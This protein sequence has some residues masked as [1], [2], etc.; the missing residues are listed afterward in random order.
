MRVLVAPD[1]LKGCLTN[2][3]VAQ[4]VA[5]GLHDVWPNAE[6]VHRP[7]SDGGEGLVNALAATGRGAFVR[8]EVEGPYGRHTTARYW[9]DGSTAVVE[10]A[11]ASGL[12]T[13]RERTPL[14]ASSRGT[15]TLVRHALDGGARD[16]WLGAGG[17]A[18]VDGGWGALEALGFRAV[19]ATGAPLA[20]CGGQLSAID[21]IEPPPD[22]DAMRGRLR[23]LC[24]VTNPMT[25]P[26]GAA[27]VYGPQ[28]G[29]DPA[30]VRAL[31]AGLRHFAA[32]LAARFGRDPASMPGAGAGGGISGGLWAALG[33]PL[34]PGLDS[35]AELIQLDTA[36]DTAELA[37]TAEGRVDAQTGFGK[38]VA[39]FGERCAA[40]ETPMWI[41]AGEVTPEAEAWADDKPYALVP[42]APG[43][44]SLADSMRE[45][46]VLLRRAVARTARLWSLAAR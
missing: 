35:V 10:M 16:V 38:T 26:A 21:A 39:A 4:A 40:R 19:D 1:S 11:E 13:T 17:S 2:V 30:T 31:D 8:V 12:S 14:R 44:L 36:L 28:K 15:G 3:A 18:T 46:A 9:R 42:L 32:R 33:A 29:A 45:A 23:I 37:V 20:P 25:G 43:P 34:V 22:I 41:L 24:D 7:L 27:A 5:G 6:V